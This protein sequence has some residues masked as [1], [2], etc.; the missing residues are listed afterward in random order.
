MTALAKAALEDLLKAK[1]LENTLFPCGRDQEPQTLAMA[2]TEVEAIDSAL[3]GGLPRGHLSEIVG[4]C[5]TGRMGALCAAFA[6]ATRRGELVALVDTLDTFDPESAAAAGI[7]LS[8]LLWVRGRSGGCDE[9][10]SRAVDRAF[11]ALGLLLHAGAFGV[12]A[13]DLVNVPDRALHRIPFTTWL[14]LPRVIEGR[15]T[16]CVL[17][18]DRPIARSAAGM[19]VSLQPVGS[20]ARW[21]GGVG[22]GRLLRGLEAAVRINGARRLH[23]GRSRPLFMS[24]G[25]VRR[26]APCSQS[27]SA[28]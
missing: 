20:T 24:A 5:S 14:R 26:S 12:V 3:G 19:T 22:G 15:P 17:V 27:C 8:R 25:A 9:G 2:P 16:A 4:P 7:D 18:G 6:A 13:L 28:S 21:S 1:K 10:Q 23:D 11:K